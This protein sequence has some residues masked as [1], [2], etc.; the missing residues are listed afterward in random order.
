MFE[1]IKNVIKEGRYNLT[2]LLV[3]IDTLWVQGSLTD[4]QKATL[5]Q[6]AQAGADFGNSIDVLAKIE[7][8]DAR[9]RALEG[10]GGEIAEYTPGTW[11]YSGDKVSF[12]GK[13]YVCIAPSG[14]VCTWSPAE[15]PAYWQEME[16]GYTKSTADSGAEETQDGGETEETTA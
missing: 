9:V 4:E 10:A 2:E 14:Q 7:E 11:Y 6:E 13:K 8:L 1:V 16:A 5:V 15:Y 3:K 12:G